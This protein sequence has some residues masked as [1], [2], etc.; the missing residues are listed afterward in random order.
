MVET[1]QYADYLKQKGSERYRE[2]QFAAESQKQYDD[3]TN[4]WTEKRPFGLIDC[5]IDDVQAQQELEDYLAQN[6]I[7]IFAKYESHDGMHYILPNRDAAKLD[8]KRFDVKYRP[9]NAA[10]TRRA[11]DEMV[12]FKGDACLLLYS[13]CGY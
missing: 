10:V 12:T 2:F 8:F 13:A 3:A 4:K 11:S 6:N 1:N 5:D 7:K 9:V